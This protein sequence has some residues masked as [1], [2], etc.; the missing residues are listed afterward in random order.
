MGERSSGGER[1]SFSRGFVFSEAV[2]FV[3]GA[4]VLPVPLE[5]D[6]CCLPALCVGGR[7]R[8][9]G[10]AV[11]GVVQGEPERRDQL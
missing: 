3:S 6:R 4:C 7:V 11:G 8:L 9:G 10:G 2:I 1:A 5:D